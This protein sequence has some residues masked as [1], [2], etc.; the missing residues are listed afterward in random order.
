MQTAKQIVADALVSHDEKRHFW[1]LEYLAFH[2]IDAL[3][4]YG[5]LDRIVMVSRSLYMR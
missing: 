5:N 2:A 4:E 1:L 3:R